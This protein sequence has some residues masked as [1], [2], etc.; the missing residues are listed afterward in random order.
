M[1]FCLSALG[2]RT[3]GTE[4][5]ESIDFI[6]SFLCETIKLLHNPILMPAGG[7]ANVE[8]VASV[9]AAASVETA[10]G[11]RPFVRLEVG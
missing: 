1:E 2:S 11:L 6:D 5:T 7:F 9:E 8:A 10:K 4:F 3:K